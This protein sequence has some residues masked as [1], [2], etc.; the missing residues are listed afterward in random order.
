M[1]HQQLLAD[2]KAEHEQMTLLMEKEHK[3]DKSDV[4]AHHLH[5][6]HELKAKSEEK[7]RELTEE[8]GTLCVKTFHSKSFPK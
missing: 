2:V 5:E 4:V 8:S 6:L 7:V 3:K 1:W